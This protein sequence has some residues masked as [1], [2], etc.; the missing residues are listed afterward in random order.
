MAVLG[1]TISGVAHE[2]NNPLASILTWAERL[3]R[4]PAGPEHPP[5]ARHH[6][7]RS[8][9]RRAHRPPPA[10]VRAQAAHDARH[11]RR[12]RRRPRHAG[13]AA[14]R[15]AARQHRPDRRAGGRACRTSSPTRTSCSRSLLNLVI[16]AEQAMTTAAGRGTL[17][18]RT[19]HDGERDVV[20]LE[21]ADDGPG[22]APEVLP[23]IFDPFF[24]TKEV[25]Q[26]TGLGLTVAYAIIQ[27]HGGA[28]TAH[29][30]PGEGAT[31]RIELPTASTQ[32]ARSAP[33][34]PI[35]PSPEP[36]GGR[37]GAAGRRRA[38]AGVRRRR[39]PGRRGLRRDARRRRRGGARRR[40]PRA[41]FDA[42]I[43]DLKMPRLDGPA[44]YRAIVEHYAGAGA[45]GDLRHRRRRRHRSRALPRRERLPLAA[46][47]VPAVGAA[48]RR[49]RGRRVGHQHA[50][51]SVGRARSPCRS[52]WR[53][54]APPGSAA[55]DVVGEA[56]AER[57]L[58]ALDG[59]GVE[60]RH[61]RFVDPDLGPDLLHRDVAEVIEPD[62]LALARGQRLRGPGGRASWS[63]TSRSA[64]S[65]VGVSGGTQTS[66][67]IDVGRRR[68]ATTTASTSTRWC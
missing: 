43:C 32:A 52:A 49:P 47:A 33:D 31:F 44:F 64:R 2:L 45:A 62:D 17:V 13:A 16:N 60:L 15:A 59:A 35:G 38:G 65:G 30:A 39:M 25:G 29:S 55:S 6:P 9:A 22:M 51:R 42:V 28:I 57:L 5:G 11:R 63:P 56:A 36:R 66:G 10:D 48:A 37:G 34:P 41:T 20:L 23:R 19:W 40:R 68:P 14:A 21:V 54:L 61:A 4:K 58:Q 12:Q 8:R 3:A 27:E 24:T 1:Q 53:G 18:V 46:Q 50:A 7:P 67:S 26:G